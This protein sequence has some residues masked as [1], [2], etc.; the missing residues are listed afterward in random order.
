MDRYQ[1]TGICSFKELTDGEAESCGLQY[2]MIVS[3][4]L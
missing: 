3:R 2:M 1:E 4:G